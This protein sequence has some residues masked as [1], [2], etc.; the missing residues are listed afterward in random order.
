M[1]RLS[2]I[3]TVA[4]AEMRLTRRL[5]RYWVALVL[6]LLASLIIYIYYASLHA[7]FS[8]LSATVSFIGPRFL[9]GG[10][11]TYFIVL[12]MLGL[13]FLG[14]DVRARD[15]RERVAEVL[16]ARPISTPELLVGRFLGILVMAWIPALLSVLGMQLLGYGLPL[17][18]APIGQPLHGM[19]TIV[20]LTGMTIPAFAFTLA[21]IFF[22]VLAV[23]HRLAA[24]LL[25]IAAVAASVWA[26]WTVAPVWNPF[27]DV[28][29]ASAIQFASDMVGGMMPLEGWAQRLGMLVAAL[30]FIAFSAAVHPRPDGGSRA[31]RALVGAALLVVG[32][33]L[34]GFTSMT[35][36]AVIADINHWSTV[37]A[38]AATDLRPDV[39][40]M[41]ARV[42]LDAGGRLDASL[43]LRV[44]GPPEGALDVVR[45]TLNPG[46]TVTEASVNGS[47]AVFTH[48]DGLLDIDHPLASGEVVALSLR[49]EGR[50]NRVF[51]Y[52]DAT[53]NTET[54][55]TWNSQLYALGSDRFVAGRNVVALL[56]GTGWLPVAG[57]SSATGL[58]AEQ[59][60]D[61]FDLDLTV[62]APEPWIV[63]GP[64]AR[65][66]AEDGWVRFAPGAPVDGVALIAGRFEQRAVDVAGIR[67]EL[68]LW[69]EH[70]DVLEDLA[71]AEVPLRDFIEERLSELADAGLPYPYTGFS[72]VEVPNT[73]RGF[74]G[75]WMLDT[76]MAPPGMALVHET[77]L[78]M[79]RFDV[80]FRD[81]E[82]FKEREGGLPEAQLNRLKMFCTNDFSGTNVFANAARSFVRSRTGARGE[83]REGADWIVADLATRLLS[84]TRS[85]FSAHLF[86]P[87]LNQAIGQAI[88]RHFTSGGNRPFAESVVEL[89]SSRPEV[90]QAVEGSNL[91]SM[92]P[93]E[94]PR[95]T[96]DA[97]ALK[98]GTLADVSYL[99]LGFE[100]SAGLLGDLVNEYGGRTFDL[101]GLSEFMEG[102]AEGSGTMVDDIFRSTELPAFAERGAEV[103]RVEDTED[104]S[105][106][107]ELVTVIDNHRPNPGVVQ[108]NIR[109]GQGDEAETLTQDPVLIPGNSGVR[110]ATVLSQPPSVVWVNP[111]LSVNRTAF[112]IAVDGPGDEVDPRAPTEGMEVVALED[113]ASDAIVVDDLDDGFAVIS[114]KGGNGLRLT[115]RESGDGEVLDQGL[116]VDEFGP[117]PRTWS[118]AT[119]GSAH[120]LYRHTFAYVKAGKGNTRAE[121]TAT[122]PRAGQ[123]DLEIHVPVKRR[124]FA[125]RTWGMWTVV[126]DQ[127]GDRT[128]LEF[129]AAAAEGGW[130]LLDTLDLGD[131]EVTVQIADDV[132]GQIVVADAIR[133]TPAGGGR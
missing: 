86:T 82:D 59:G 75:G 116:P 104:G 118:R 11:G 100:G 37:H 9:I 6:S 17:L 1:M 91:L 33:G 120:G 132:T 72:V 40:S 29:G 99:R 71:E 111:F 121:F 96:L 119:S 38:A 68:L 26:A 55:N 23:R 28:M 5:A 76:T 92:D 88:Q 51:G 74:G 14:Y 54:V 41:S 2:V 58:A 61:F 13:V 39:R 113:L 93:L 114:E 21:F 107:Y 60:P 98:A 89:F 106:R 3:R 62:S 25:G 79:A 27:F 44:A 77:G 85:Y 95:R 4:A 48:A 34:M 108:L 70:T 45:F 126:V 7:F 18:G 35:R 78:P 24:A 65:E 73:L 130:S 57:P 103:V 49:L 110:M 83:G 117:T 30:A 94:N 32:L 67:F 52:V 64:G 8:S 115:A 42:A 10:M 46:L 101:Q 127:D 20:F 125:I 16:D 90:W 81:P 31:R 43:D 109:V 123:Y 47:A 129:D 12:F 66:P 133:W 122:L 56:P 15:Q 97:Y 50:P 105:P 19:S 112:R 128:E 22:L 131:G 84:E 80:P 63:A 69:P 53:K 36:R 87:E 124:F 102:R